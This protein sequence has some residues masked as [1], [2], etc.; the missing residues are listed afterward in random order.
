MDRRNKAIVA[1]HRAVRA[2]IVAGMA[3][4]SASGYVKVADVA[5]CVILEF[6]KVGITTKVP[7]PAAVARRAADEQHRR[8]E[9]LGFTAQLSGAGAVELRYKCDACAALSINGTP[10][11]EIGCPNA[12]HECRGCNELVPMNQRYCAECM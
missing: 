6:D 12:R 5:D 7:S 11:H 4:A 3:R 2:A 9:A 1:R 10:T 8:M